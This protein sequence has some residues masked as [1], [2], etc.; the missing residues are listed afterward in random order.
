MKEKKIN[1]MSRYTPTEVALQISIPLLGII[2]LG[3]YE[4][5]FR[6]YNNSN[7]S[8]TI[9]IK[10]LEDKDNIKGYD[11]VILE[12]GREFKIENR[13]GKLSLLERPLYKTLELEEKVR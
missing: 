8:K 3:I 10:S 6:D 12:D 11:T 4:S 7:P 5:Y 13:D 1:L 2:C 9:Q